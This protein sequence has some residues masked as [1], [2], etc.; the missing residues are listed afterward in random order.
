MASG[1]KQLLRN[2]MR[3]ALAEL[4]P[5]HRAEASAKIRQH[6]ANF[7]PYREARVVYGVC[8]MKSEPD[9]I[10]GAL[11]ADKVIC[12]PRI[13]GRTLRFLK[14]GDLSELVAGPYGVLEPPS[15]PRAP[16]PDLVLAPGMAFD[17][18]GNRLGRG[19]GFFD[20]FL[21][22]NQYQFIGLAFACQL[23]RRVPAYDHDQ[24]ISA[25]I[26][27]DGVTICNGE[28]PNHRD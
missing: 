9:W 17:R 20:R 26:T 15:G 19:A 27:E 7:P 2:Q 18:Q 13:D 12:M 16:A 8:P 28:M 23:I 25:L 5:T 4:T 3:R 24:R 6:L 22:T 21:H 11:P 10:G 1:E 14:V